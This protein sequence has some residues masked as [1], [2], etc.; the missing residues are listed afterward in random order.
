M[1]N[2]NLDLNI[3]E[4]ITVDFRALAYAIDVL[5]GLDVELTRQEIGHLNNYNIETAK[6]CEVPYEEVLI[7][8]DV[9]FDGARTRSFHL[10]GTQAVSYARI[11]YTDGG[12][13]R[14]ASRQ[15]EVLRLV[16]E[17]ATQADIGTIDS[18]LNTVLP[19][20]TTNL[21]NSKLIS[22]VMNVMSYTLDQSETSGFPLVRVEDDGSITGT[23][24]LIPVTLEY[25]V[26]ILHNYIFG[27]GTGYSPSPTVREYSQHI[28][29]LS[30]YGPES[31]DA[32]SQYDYHD[33]IVR[34]SEEGEAA[35]LAEE[36]AAAAA[37][38]TAVESY[39]SSGES[40]DESGETYDESA[41]TYDESG[42]T[43]DDSGETYDES[44]E[45][46]DESG[47]NYDESGEVYVES[48]E[49]YDGSGEEGLNQ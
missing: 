43:Y 24:C 14:R 7:P 4:Y 2:L 47:E 48:A 39:D 25:D 17:K 1:L 8:D 15:R 9:S 12:D 40:Y 28:V 30:G 5:G 38:G 26:R 49:N 6:V 35:A 18:L 41:E 3:Q 31:I 23:D 10:N 46:Y 42:E 34:W 32:V 19:Y 16:K 33:A 27:E 36:A 11:R 29:D 21:D 44:G 37:A 13:Y 22:L 45:N 20:V